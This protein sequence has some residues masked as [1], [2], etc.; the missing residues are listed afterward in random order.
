MQLDSEFLYHVRPQLPSC[1]FHGEQMFLACPW[2]AAWPL[3][4]RPVLSRISQEKGIRRVLTLVRKQVTIPFASTVAS[5]PLNCT[6]LPTS[7]TVWFVKESRYCW[8]TRGVEIGS[9]VAAFKV[10]VEDV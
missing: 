3:P 8:L 1:C 5:S 10:Q 2:L 6:T 9:I 7:L 4:G